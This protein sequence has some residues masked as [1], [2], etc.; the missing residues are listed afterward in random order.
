MFLFSQMYD[1]DRS[2][3]ISKEELAA[4]LRVSAKSLLC[5]LI[6]VQR[7]DRSCM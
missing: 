5:S 2:G 6:L 7:I 4:M 3:C 1:A